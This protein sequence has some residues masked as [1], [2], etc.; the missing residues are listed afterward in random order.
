MVPHTQVKTI[1]EELGIGF[2]GVGFDPKW[3]FKDIPVMPKVGNTGIT[4]AHAVQRHGTAIRYTP[5]L[6]RDI[7]CLPTC[8]RGKHGIH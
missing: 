6:L 5:S 8:F 3:G 4:A 7:Q 1:G 2:L